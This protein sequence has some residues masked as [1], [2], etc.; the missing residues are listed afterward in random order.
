MKTVQD[1]MT[2][3]VISVNPDTPIV[4]AVNI[5]LKNSF[6]GLPVIDKDNSLM[7]ILTEYELLIKGSSVYLPTVIKFINEIDLYKKDRG[8]IKVDIEKIL[9]TKVGDMMN[10]VPLS[11]PQHT[12]IEEAIKIFEA[13]HRVNPIPVLDDNKKVVGILSRSDL[14]K[15]FQVPTLKNISP[16]EIDKNV[17]LFL[18]NLESRFILVSRFRTHFWLVA[19]ILF[20]IVGYFIAWALILRIN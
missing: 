9:S 19:S 11:M 17:N 12:P 6:T 7:G 5:L 3:V 10:Y 8:L 1:I 13:H 2:R 16:R 18:E 14:I 15:F 4:E 20:A